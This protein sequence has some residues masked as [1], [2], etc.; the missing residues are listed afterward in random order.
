MQPLPLGLST[1]SPLKTSAQGF[2][3]F[4]LSIAASSLDY[5]QLQT[6]M[7]SSPSS[8]DI[9]PIA[10]AAERH[11]HPKKKACL[12]S[13]S[14]AGRSSFASP[15][16][17]VRG[18]IATSPTTTSSN[19][20][21]ILTNVSL[22]SIRTPM[23]PDSIT[24]PKQEPSAMKADTLEGAGMLLAA[25]ALLNYTGEEDSDVS[26]PFSNFNDDDV[27]FYE[28]QAEVRISSSSA[29]VS[30]DSQVGD[31]DDMELRTMTPILSVEYNPRKRYAS[32]SPSV[33]STP[34]NTPGGRSMAVCSIELERRLRAVVRKQ[35]KVSHDAGLISV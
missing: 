22:K 33:P 14:R 16:L 4:D 20:T 9:Y 12:G 23:T 34:P 29:S 2:S 24:R 8:I 15:V 27:D 26:S 18:E 7:Q 30:S 3:A 6:I 1:S 5:S 35:L 28:H 32:A 25:A 11:A 13:P 19:T 17:C 31:L 21:P 10:P